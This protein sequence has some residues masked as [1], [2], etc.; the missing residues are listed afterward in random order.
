M[1]LV[2]VTYT[3]TGL[4]QQYAEMEPR[5]HFT[6][7]RSGDP[8]QTKFLRIIRGMYLTDVVHV[9]KTLI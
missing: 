2:E 4:I 9:A 1:R 6:L 5:S 7:A 3:P 8:R